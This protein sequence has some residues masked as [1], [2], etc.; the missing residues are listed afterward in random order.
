MS[1][2]PRAFTELTAMGI[3]CREGVT[4]MV[5]GRTLCSRPS[6]HCLGHQADALPSKGMLWGGQTTGGDGTQTGKF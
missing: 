3:S 4:E 1:L 6:G 2:L 5:R